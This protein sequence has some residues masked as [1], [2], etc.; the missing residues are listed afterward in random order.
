MVALRL[1]RSTA[2]GRQQRVRHGPQHRL[3]HREIDPRHAAGPSA[4]PDAGG[5]DEGQ[6][7]AAHRIEPGEPDARRNSR[8]AGSAR[9]SRRSIA[10]AC[11]K[12]RRATPVRCGPCPTPRRTSGWGCAAAARLAPSPRRSITPVAKFSTSTSHRS[13]SARATST[14]AG[15]FRS[16]TM[17]RFAWPRTVCSS[18]ARPGSPR[19][20]ASTLITSAPIAAR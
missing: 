17:P 7:H 8:D 6:H 11:R 3:D 19:P 10:A 16:S 15:C 1:R 2:L 20:G 9:R 4:L 12:R 5:D 18:D 13:A 14:A